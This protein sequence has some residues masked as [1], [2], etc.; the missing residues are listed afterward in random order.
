MN[1]FE[2]SFRDINFSANSFVRAYTKYEAGF[3]Q[4]YSWVT[5]SKIIISPLKLL[6]KTRPNDK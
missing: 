6:I 3:L 5:I 4:C 2:S 1:M